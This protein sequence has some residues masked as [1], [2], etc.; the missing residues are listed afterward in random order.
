MCPFW[1]HRGI[2]LKYLRLYADANGES[3][4][5]EMSVQFSPIDSAPPAPP[6]G[7]SERI[8]ATGLIYVRFPAGWTSDLHPTPRRQLFVLLAGDFSG[9]ASDGALMN[10]V[11]GDVLL[12]EDTFGKGHTGKVNGT[13][14]V[15]AMMIHLE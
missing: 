5:E 12:M 10:L 11:P 1:K 4:V 9:R 14:D 7:R 13:E 8:E 3:H 2:S 6:F 15:H